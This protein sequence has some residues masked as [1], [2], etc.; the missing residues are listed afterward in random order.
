MTISQKDGEGSK[1]INISKSQGG[2]DNNEQEKE[3]I[4]NDDQPRDAEKNPLW[5][6][7]I[8]MGNKWG[9]GRERDRI[10]GGTEG[11]EEGLDGRKRDGGD[12]GEGEGGREEDEK[13]RGGKGMEDMQESGGTETQM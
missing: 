6:K 11:K 7:N 13:G 3:L 1:K 9:G 10:G 4:G 2:V 8:L 5:S 12:R